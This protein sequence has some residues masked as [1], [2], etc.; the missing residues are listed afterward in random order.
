MLLYTSTTFS[1]ETID[2]V[3]EPYLKDG[4]ITEELGNFLICASVYVAQ[5]MKLHLPPEE[6]DAAI[7][8]GS[9]NAIK[10]G[11]KQMHKVDR[12][13]RFC[14]LLLACRSGIC[15]HLELFNTY[16]KQNIPVDFTQP[17]IDFALA[18]MNSD[19]DNLIEEDYND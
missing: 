6:R 1:Q 14:Y 12:T 8:N 13:K 19:P 15:R 5:K 4:T 2:R 11:L 16:R 9:I 18:Q 17:D 7:L 3:L 10:Y